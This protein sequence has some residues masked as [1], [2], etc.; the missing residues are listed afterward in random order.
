MAVPRP[1]GGE[2]EAGARVGLPD[3]VFPGAHGQGP[4]RG[5][6]PR[7]MP[8]QAGLRIE[9]VAHAHAGRDRGEH[10]QGAEH[11]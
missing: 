11:D 9:H 7:T 4:R 1:F 5:I 6:S 2:G 10:D 3:R 8:G